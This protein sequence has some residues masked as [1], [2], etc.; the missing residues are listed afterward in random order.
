[1]QRHGGG[2]SRR[3]SCGRS[4]LL[5]PR[6]P[7]EAGRRR[8]CS[9]SRRRSAWGSVDG[10]KACRPPLPQWWALAKTGDIA[11]AQNAASVLLT[12]HLRRTVAGPALLC[13]VAPTLANGG[14]VAAAE[15]FRAVTEQSPSSASGAE[16]SELLAKLRALLKTALERYV[17]SHHRSKTA[18]KRAPSG[19][20]IVPL[21][22][23]T[24]LSAQDPGPDGALDRAWA[25]E[26]VAEAVRRTREHYAD[27]ARL[28]IWQV[29]EL[30]F[31]GPT[32]HGES[33]PSRSD[34]AR[35]VGYPSDAKV[36]NA[37]VT[38]KRTLARTLRDALLE[39]VG[40]EAL[41]DQELVAR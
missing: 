6:R 18:K 14:Y 36:S 30:G 10:E 1:M 21:D 25:V 28:D 16:A 29:F 39:Y 26:V 40:D 31:L 4:R 41:V 37:I 32:L 17:L 2:P 34:L 9:F 27:T 35:Q 12:E 22:G 38:A 19:R 8:A 7:T 24:S 33:S 20:L 5:P 15:A 11:G 23:I 13:Q 3:A